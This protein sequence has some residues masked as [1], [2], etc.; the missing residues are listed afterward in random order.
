MDMVTLLKDSLI[1]QRISGFEKELKRYVVFGYQANRKRG[2]LIAQRGFRS[3]RR[4]ERHA[5]YLKRWAITS[6]SLV[7]DTEDLGFKLQADDAV[8]ITENGTL[9]H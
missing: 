2:Y 8:L 1:R 6:Y 5:R 3:L 9:I 4:A 7:V